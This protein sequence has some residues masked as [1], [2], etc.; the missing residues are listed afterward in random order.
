MI[1]CVVLVYAFRGRRRRRRRQQ[2]VCANALNV[3]GVRW[4]RDGDDRTDG[5]SDIE[6]DGGDICASGR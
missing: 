6:Y 4:H 1:W 5:D 2:H 3:V